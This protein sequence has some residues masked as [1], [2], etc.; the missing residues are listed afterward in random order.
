MRSS[1]LCRIHGLVVA[2]DNVQLANLSKIAV[3]MFACGLLLTLLSRAH[4]ESSQGMPGQNSPAGIYGGTRSKSWTPLEAVEL[5]KD[6]MLTCSIGQVLVGNRTQKIPTK[7][8]K[9]DAYE[10]H[11]HF[12]NFETCAASAGPGDY[13]QHFPARAVVCDSRSSRA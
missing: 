11:F 13:L 3:E 4:P 1:K 6:L 7:D 9:D 5:F 10:P 8:V 12:R 2:I